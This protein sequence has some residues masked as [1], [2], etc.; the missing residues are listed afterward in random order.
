MLMSPAIWYS[1]TSV[2]VSEPPQA[3]PPNVTLHPPLHPPQKQQ[4]GRDP[5]LRVIVLQ[6]VTNGPFPFV[7]S[8]ISSYS[9]G[10]LIYEYLLESRNVV[11]F[12]EYQHCLLVINRV[13]GPE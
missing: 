1:C 4:H 7:L 13:N 6:N 12:V 11:L 2:P 3:Y 10:K 8:E 5:P 9:K